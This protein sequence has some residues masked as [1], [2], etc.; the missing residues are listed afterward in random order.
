MSGGLRTAGERNPGTEWRGGAGS[1]PLTYVEHVGATVDCE[2]IRPGLLGQPANA[3]SCLVFIVAGFW[4]LR[5]AATRWVGLA[6]VATG[7]GSFLFHGPLAP[8]GAWIHDVTL[9]WLLVVIIVEAKQWR[10]GIHLAGAGALAVGFAAFP[11]LAEPAMAVMAAAGIALLLI[12][13]RS[14]RTWAPL[15]VLAVSAMVGRLGGTGGPLCDPGSIVQPHALWHVGAA[16]AV[17][18]WTGGRPSIRSH[19]SGR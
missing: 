2:A 4:L 17:T 8:D 1:T 11:A 12:D 7:T 18:W 19:S 13:D 6:L 14:L 3:L 5:R 16:I 15:S 9:A 10:T